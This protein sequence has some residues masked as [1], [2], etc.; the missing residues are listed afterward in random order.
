LAGGTWGVYISTDD[1]LTWIDTKLNRSIYS[2]AIDSSNIFA[3]T[4][5]SGVYLSTNNGTTWA[6]TSLNYGEI[7]ALAI[8]EHYIFAGTWAHGIYISSDNGAS[9]IQSVLNNQTVK[10]FAIYESI[11]YSGTSEGIFLSTNN[12][13][14]WIQKNDGFNI[15]PYIS[16]FLI[17]DNYLF[18]GTYSYSVWKR[19]LSELLGTQKISSTIPQEFHLCQNYPNPFNPVT[20]IKFDI[21]TPL[22]PPEGEK[23]GFITLIIY[24]VL[25]CEIAVLVN[26]QLKPGTYEVEWDGTNYPSGVYFYKLMAGDYSAAKRM[27][28]LK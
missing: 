18:A 8:N 5:Y 13:T 20:K 11:I 6:Q 15:V 2:L 22:T 24:D 4:S 21:P 28:L 26:E 7:D 17:N 9:W 1:G 19:P 12:G 16:S 27:I 25:G 23:S 14:T 10:S 3:G